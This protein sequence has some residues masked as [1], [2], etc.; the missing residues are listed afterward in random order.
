MDIR[1][2][3]PKDADAR[4]STNEEDEQAVQLLSRAF[5]EDPAI[6]AL[7]REQ[8]AEK[9]RQRMLPFFR[10]SL[11]ACKKYGWLLFLQDE[12]Q[13]IAGAALAYRPGQYPLPARAQWT[14]MSNTVRGAG[15][16][17]LHRWA[18]WMVR[19]A[20]NHPHHPPHY[21][22]ELIGIEPER[23][24]Q[25]LGSRLLQEILVA[26]D[27]EKVGCFLETSNLRNLPFYQRFGFQIRAEAKPLG[28]PTYYLWREGR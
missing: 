26:A 5:L 18:W 27:R 2:A 3:N 20:R 13:A 17:G 21:Y 28:V 16:S 15:I 19:A 9:R 7:L 14:M 24:G 6:G 10:T 11:A 4:P 1:I 12:H 22:L 25:G 8:D 23:Q